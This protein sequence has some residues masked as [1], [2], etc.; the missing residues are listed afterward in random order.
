[1]KGGRIIIEDCPFIYQVDWAMKYTVKD[2][3]IDEYRP[4]L[5]ESIEAFLTL[6]EN[7]F[8]REKIA[9]FIRKGVQYSSMPLEV[10]F[11]ALNDRG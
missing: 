5:E 8:L 9:A 4:D 7:I 6:L 10:P 11:E 1:M 2:D 3:T